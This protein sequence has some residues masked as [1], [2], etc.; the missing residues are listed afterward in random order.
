MLSFD[1]GRDSKP[2]ECERCGQPFRLVKLFVLRD[3]ASHAVCFVALHTHEDVREAWLDVILGTWG[4]D[5][6]TIS[7]TPTPF[8]LDGRGRDQ[9]LVVAAL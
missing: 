4:E 7:L 9:T 8:L 5:D 1:E 6:S 3:D 2:Q